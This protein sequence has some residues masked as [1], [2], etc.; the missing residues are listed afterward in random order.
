MPKIPT[1]NIFLHLWVNFMDLLITLKYWIFFFLMSYQEKLQPVKCYLSR[2][3]TSRKT[4]PKKLSKFSFLVFSTDFFFEFCPQHLCHFEYVLIKYPNQFLYYISLYV[5]GL[6]KKNS[7]LS[8][9]LSVCFQAS[10]I[11]M[12]FGKI[13]YRASFEINFTQK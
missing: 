11:W 12:F 2:I 1:N 13:Y 10:K 8:F 9:I 4:E 3:R 5:E 7:S 6:M